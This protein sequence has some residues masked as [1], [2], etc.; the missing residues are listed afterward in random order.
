MKSKLP[1]LRFVCVSGFWDK[2]LWETEL[3]QMMFQKLGHFHHLTPFSDF[4]EQYLKNSQKEIM[5]TIN[6]YSTKQLSCTD[7]KQLYLYRA[8]FFISKAH[9]SNGSPDALFMPH[10]LQNE[11]HY[12]IKFICKLHYYFSYLVCSRTEFSKTEDRQS[13]PNINSYKTPSPQD[14]SSWI[15]S[16]TLLVLLLLD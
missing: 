15:P 16:L 4:H 10:K 14:F 13:N 9:P 6:Q 2:H 8:V 5:K 7:R 12:F 3:H 1:P 11:K